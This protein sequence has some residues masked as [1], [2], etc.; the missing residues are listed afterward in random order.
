MDT[1]K[2]RIILGLTE[3]VF[4]LGK[5]EHGEALKKSCIAR[6]DTGAKRSS[7]DIHLA[8]SLGIIPSKQKA[9]IRSATGRTIRPLASVSIILKDKKYTSKFTLIDRTPMSYQCLIGTD[10][11]EKDFIIDPRKK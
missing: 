10:I 3:H 1:F 5:Q 6:I 8:K 7:I 9:V 4:I 2:G 11:L